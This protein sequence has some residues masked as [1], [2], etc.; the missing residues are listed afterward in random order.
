MGQLCCMYPEACH[1]PWGGKPWFPFHWIYLN[2]NIINIRIHLVLQMGP[3]FC[4]TV[5]N[6][7][8]MLASVPMY[9]WNGSFKDQNVLPHLLSIFQFIYWDRSKLG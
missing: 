6:S 8:G 3:D 5:W 2:C 7:P 9:V 1:D 4:E